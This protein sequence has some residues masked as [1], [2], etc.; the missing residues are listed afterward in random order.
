MRYNQDSM[1]VL[2]IVT[3]ENNPILRT[4]T[5][6]AGGITEEVKT[7]IADMRDTLAQ[8]KGLGLAA[9][10]VGSNLR[11]CLVTLDE[12]T[13]PLINPEIIKRSARTTVDEEGCLSLPKLWLPVARAVEI[14]IQ[15][16]DEKGKVKERTLEGFDAR[17]VQ[18]ELDH[19]DGVLIVD[20]QVKNLLVVQNRAQKN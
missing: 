19:L 20:Y 4:K 7:L 12:K 18:H 11:V 1:A 14:T 8:A 6:K 10:Q 3:G 9:P 13:F 15:Y 17:V 2:P 16:M 5:R